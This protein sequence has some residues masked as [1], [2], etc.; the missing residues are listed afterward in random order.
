MQEPKTFA[1]RE[2]YFQ[3][4]NIGIKVRPDYS[5]RQRPTRHPGNK[6]VTVS[7]RSFPIEISVD[8]DFTGCKTQ[9]CLIVSSSGIGKLHL[10][11]E[12]GKVLPLTQNA[13]SQ[14]SIIRIPIQMYTK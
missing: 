13:E 3:D 4:D 2:K 6:K 7:R 1:M 9:L 12:N 10:C 8:T 14:N 11:D 5:G